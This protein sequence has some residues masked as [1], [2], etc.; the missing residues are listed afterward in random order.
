M[1]RF[2]I[3]LIFA[4]VCLTTVFLLLPGCGDGRPRRVPVS[5]VVLIDGKPL[6]CGFVRFHPQGGR[7]A[8]GEID[9]QGHFTLSCF[10][11]NDGVVPGTHP[12]SVSAFEAVNSRATRWHAPKKYVSPKTSGLTQT[13]EGPTDSV[14]IELTWDGGKP[15]VERIIE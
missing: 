12:V 4:T 14:K 7:P 10:E 8:T 13:I 2:K 1:K 15:F 3:N 5:G 6:T 9:E 11:D